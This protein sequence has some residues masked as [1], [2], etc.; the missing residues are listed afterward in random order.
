LTGVEPVKKYLSKIIALS[1]INKKRKLK[2][3]PVDPI[4]KHL[5]LTGNPGTGKTTVARMLG[6][7][8]KDLGLLS[9]GHFVEVG[10][11]DL[12]AIYTG[13]TASKTAKVIDSAKGGVLFIDEAY[14]LAG[15]GKGGFGA[16]AIEVLVKEMEN[17]RDDL[18]VIVAG[19]QADM[20]N[21]LN[22]NEGLKSRFSEKIVS[23]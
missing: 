7:I 17:F 15:K 6:E 14:S 8:Y 21:F 3:L 1:E 10:Q 5:V 9:K 16:E 2:G 11:Q 13:Q 23:T 19:Y 20:E 18:V 12:V 4:N 22:S